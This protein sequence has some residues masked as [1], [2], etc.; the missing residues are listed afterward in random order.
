MKEKINA[1]IS[2]FSRVVCGIFIFASIYTAFFSGFNRAVFSVKDVC[3]IFV[4][5]LVSAIG[6]LPLLADKPLSKTALIIYQIIY[7]L[8]IN[9]TALGAGAILGWFNL[10]NKILVI[11]FEIVVIA[12]YACVML[13]SYRLDT[14]EADKMNQKLRE[15]KE[16]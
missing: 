9:A 5:G 7:F 15:R 12:V 2:V 1:M 11:S 6:I 10:K 4:I 14:N 16:R 13:I 8:I 3:A